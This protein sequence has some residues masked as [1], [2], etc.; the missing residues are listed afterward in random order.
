M[1]GRTSKQRKPSYI[2]MYRDEW[3]INLIERSYIYI[4]LNYVIFH[5]LAIIRTY[6]TKVFILITVEFL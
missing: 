2:R 6:K 3:F 1:H 5:T 4:Y